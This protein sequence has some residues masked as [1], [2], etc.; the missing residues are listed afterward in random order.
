MRGNADDLDEQDLAQAAD[1]S[2]IAPSP[3]WFADKRLYETHGNI[4]ISHAE[5][6]G[7]LLSESNYEQ[8]LDYLNTVA[9]NVEHEDGDCCWDAQGQH[10]EAAHEDYVIAGRVQDWLVGPLKEIF[11]QV[12]EADGFTYTQPFREAVAIALNL[13]D[14]PVFDE[15]DYVERETNDFNTQWERDLVPSL[16][17]EHEDDTE[18][19]VNTIAGIAYDLFTNGVPYSDILSATDERQQE[20]WDQA[21][22]E[23]FGARA[24]EQLTAQI[25]GQLV[26]DI[27]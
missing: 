8:V 12:Y 10:I 13:R 19:D 2:L 7:D 25:E 16:S 3:A 1:E 22:D 26:L 4:G 6:S 9:A 24:H 18:A 5:N 14:Y 11:V 27:R 17:E 21:R 15:D 23:V 20:I